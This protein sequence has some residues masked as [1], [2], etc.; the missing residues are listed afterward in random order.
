FPE[1]LAERPAALLALVLLF[2]RGGRPRITRGFRGARWRLLAHELSPA[3]ACSASGA[4]ACEVP[5]SVVP[6]SV[7]RASGVP[8]AADPAIS[9]P[10]S[11]TGTEGGR[12]PVIRPS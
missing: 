9:R 10:S 2:R 3:P 11:S 4:P 5:A 6:A 1:D 7:V 12:K 8:G